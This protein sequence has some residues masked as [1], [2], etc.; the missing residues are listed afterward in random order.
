M[1]EYDPPVGAHFEVLCTDEGE[2][3]WEGEEPLDRGTCHGD[4]GRGRLARTYASTEGDMF[5]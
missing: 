2:S 5:W 3:W 4:M 1:T